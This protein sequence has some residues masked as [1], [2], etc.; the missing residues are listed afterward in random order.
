MA[1]KWPGLIDSLCQNLFNENITIRLAAVETLGYICVELTSRTLDSGTVDVILTGLIRSS[2][3]YLTIKENTISILRALSK[4]LP[5]AV[6]NFSNP[7][8]YF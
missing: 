1:E 5:L 7:V 6:K 4:T 8:N 3:E 2:S